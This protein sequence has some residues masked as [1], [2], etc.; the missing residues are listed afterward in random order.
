M[1]NV[2]SLISERELVD[3]IEISS[4]EFKP[5]LSHRMKIDDYCKKLIDKASLF[6]A[7]END[8][9]VGIAAFYCNDQTEKQAYLSYFYVRPKNRNQGI[10]Q[11]LLRK[12]I[13]HSQTCGMK[14][15]KVET[16][17]DNRAISL[18]RRNGFRQQGTQNS[19]GVHMVI[20]VTRFEQIWPKLLCSF[21]GCSP[22]GYTFL[23][24]SV[25]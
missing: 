14:S 10:G 13:L 19:H 25:L 21:S 17:H 23:T 16:W 1:V 4:N 3:F 18:Y 9:V 24:T 12:A 15:M 2:D 11:M 5:P 20:M 7:R 22:A 6:I 8:I